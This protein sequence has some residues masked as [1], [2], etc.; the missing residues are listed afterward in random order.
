M[1]VDYNTIIWARYAMK[2]NPIRFRDSEKIIND[3][4]E[5][6][7]DGVAFQPIN[8][9]FCPESKLSGIGHTD[10]IKTCYYKKTVTLKKSAKR[11]M[12]HFGAVDYKCTVFVN[13]KYIGSHVGGY[14]PFGFD[15][16]DATVNGENEIK[17][18][19]AD[20][21]T[22]RIASGK[23][24]LKPQSW[25]C[26]YTRTTGIWQS[27]WIEEVPESRVTEFYF[28][29][30]VN[31]VSLG[32]DLRTNGKGRFSVE[33]Y[34]ED[35][36]VGR[37]GGS[38][39]FSKKIN[40]K[41]SEKHL[42]EVGNGRLYDVVIKFGKDVVKSYFGLRE[43]KYDGY[44][45]LLNGEP[46]FQRLVLDQGFYSDGI[47]TA[48]NDEALL[49]DIKISKALGYNGA[50]LHQKVFD[51]KFLYFCDKEG[52]IVWGEFPSWGVDYANQ[53]YY[54]E[55]ISQW[56]EELKRDFNHPSIITWCPLNEV[57]TDIYDGKRQP[58]VN[59]IDNIYSFTKSFDVTRPVVDV[60][61][62]FHGHKTD[63]Y[64]YHCYLMPDELKNILEKIESNDDMDVPM[65]Y[66]KT[67]K[68]RYKKGLPTNL[69]E[70]G[71]ISFALPKVESTGD[72]EQAW[73]Y[74]NIETDEN[75][76]FKR[77]EALTELLFKYKK[78]SGYC[79]TQLYDVEQEQNGLYNYDRTDKLSEG[80]KAKIKELNERFSINLK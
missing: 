77:F 45:F 14:T 64:D 76:F 8:V 60:S 80:I 54:G 33:V 9:P 4:W 42:W 59:F 22:E 29:P 66:G 25:G 55:F 3:G 73:G 34:Y 49:N 36:L 12:L 39:E 7:F 53:D 18:F 50:R 46:V 35:K 17:L 63:V 40:V 74:G 16:T 10:Y 21:V 79:Y 2:V 78:L 52:Y 65:L 30:D 41:L 43:V 5:F 24:S 26:F 70:Y 1:E 32:V 71:G 56:T 67:I 51:P 38:I 20:D 72:R 31:K 75:A 69:S 37:K 62:G 61:G 27:V 19:V 11:I 68:L 48:P 28:Y 23:Q 44:K 57:W 6:S 47:Y 15:I 13:G 58:D